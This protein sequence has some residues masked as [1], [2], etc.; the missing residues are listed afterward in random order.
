MGGGERGRVEGILQACA[1]RTEHPQ[2]DDDGGDREDDHEGEREQHD[3]L[4]SLALVTSR[5]GFGDHGLGGGCAHP[6]Y[7][8]SMVMV[9]LS[10]IWVPNVSG[11]II[12]YV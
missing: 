4:S 5:G 2:V 7:S 12:L 9:E 1:V 3:D 11:Q 6:T 10:G 8:T